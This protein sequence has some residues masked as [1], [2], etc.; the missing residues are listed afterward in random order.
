MERKFYLPT[1]SGSVAHYF[2]RAII[3]PAKYY[4]NKPDDIQNSSEHS[5]ILSLNKWT[6]NSDCA[7]EVVLTEIEINDLEKVCDHLFLSKFPIPASRVKRI[8]FANQ[9]QMET[10]I[11]NINNGAAFVPDRLVEVD[12]NFNLD[13]CHEIELNEK[14]ELSSKDEISDKIKYYDIILGG[15]AFMRIGGKSYMNYSFNYFST[16]SFF[17][18]LIEEQTN[19]ASQ[20]KDLSFSNKF[21]GLFSKNESEWFR[22]RKYI[23]QNIEL[24]D[25][26]ALAEQE[27]EKIERKLGAIKIDSINSNSHLYELAI[28]ATYGNSKNKSADDLVT[29]LTNGVIY[30]EKIEDVAIL[31]GLNS[32]YSKLRNKYKG[33]A[34][35]SVVK[36]RLESKLDY[37]TIESVFQFVFKNNINSYSFDYIDSWCPD[38]KKFETLKGYEVYRILDTAIVAKKKQTSLEIFLE[39]YSKDIYKSIIKSI[40]PWMPSFT[41]IDENEAL[42]YFDKQLRSS[43]IV[44]IEG[45]QL[46]I[47]KNIEDEL[48]I[49]EQANIELLNSEI[50]K[51][52]LDLAEL[53]EENLRLNE[54]ISDLNAKESTQL[55]ELKNTINET[56]VEINSDELL[57]DTNVDVITPRIKLIDATETK[58]SE[59]KEEYDALNIA[60]LKKIAKEK[61]IKGY[62]KIDSAEELIK[63]IIKAPPILL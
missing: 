21:V 19:K 43:I 44:A 5:I 62:T 25:I 4:T 32:G 28:L 55:T 40:T 50:K 39:K 15:L 58:L 30:S 13:V 54:L 10:T 9:T 14:V 18:R 57:V 48:F 12:D 56:L 34:K 11:W 60:E 42:S 45:L 29:D 53:N 46:K 17:N 36:F 33:S 51:L 59:P 26:E 8:W 6:K 35:E 3:L 47:E 23:F 38:N 1:N 24:H 16:L 7:L 20:D 37:Y 63:L 22:W 61:K 41:K 49:K 2:N 27:G 31:F 52:K